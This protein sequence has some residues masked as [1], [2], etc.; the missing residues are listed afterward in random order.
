MKCM[1]YLKNRHILN[2]NPIK[3]YKTCKQCHKKKDIK[4]FASGGGTYRK[5][6]VC[7]KCDPPKDRLWVFDDL[8]KVTGSSKRLSRDHESFSAQR[9]L[10]VENPESIYD[11]ET[12][13]VDH[14]E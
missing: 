13:E 5:K 14:E 11:L 2:M 4:Y 6:D 9:L 1:V 10:S 3:Q 7:R 12:P 8:I